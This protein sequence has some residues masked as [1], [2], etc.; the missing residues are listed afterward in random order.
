[1]ISAL[2]NSSLPFI[3]ITKS[4][5]AASPSGDPIASL[6]PAATPGLPQQVLG[7]S[8]QPGPLSSA[9][10]GQ[11]IQVQSQQSGMASGGADAAVQALI[12]LGAKGAASGQ[13]SLNDDY[14]SS[15]FN[16][17]SG[18]GGGSLTRSELQQSVIAGGGTA[19][20]A[21]ALYDQL[22]TNGTG[23]V[24]ESQMA[25]QLAT[26]TKGDSFGE[27]LSA[28][29]KASGD[30]QQA[31]MQQLLGIGLTQDQASS[32]SQQMQSAGLT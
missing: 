12:A 26:P 4:I 17:A 22:D 32:L 11:L 3:S 7:S 23:S 30:S 19:Q 18:N 2:Q 1:M 21:D 6:S 10:L 9:T 8:S 15:L 14:K 24:S 25:G 31:L 20:A 13:I 27:G 5:N 16:L 29:L 28:Y